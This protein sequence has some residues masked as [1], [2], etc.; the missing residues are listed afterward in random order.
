MGAFS[1]ILIR[2]RLPIIIGVVVVTALLGSSLRFLRQEHDVLKFLPAEDPDIQLFRRASEE[3]GG[4]DVAV[5]GVESPR[6]F[7]NQGLSALRAMT[8][9]VLAVDGVYH[10]LSLTE[11]PH[12]ESTEEQFTIEPLV[13]DDIPFDRAALEEIR[14][15]VLADEMVSGRLAST[16]GQAALILCF[17]EAGAPMVGVAEEIRV[18][19][20]QHSG[21]MTLYYGG[22][23]FIQEHIGDGTRRD[24]I[25]LTPYVMLVSALATFIFFRRFLGAL[26]VLS[27]VALGAVWTLGGMAALGAPMTVV[28]TSLPMVLVAIGGAYGAHVLAAFYVAEGQTAADRVTNAL[29]EVGPPV[30]ASMLTTVAGFASFLAMDVAPMRAFGIQASVGVFLCALAALVVI[31]AVLSYGGSKTGPAPAEALAG[32]IWWLGR[33]TNRRRWLTMGVVIGVSALAGSMAWRVAPNTSIKN[34]FRPDSEPARANDFLRDR[35]GGSM[36]VHVYMQGDM[37]D[38]VV[39]DELRSIAEEARSIEGVTRITTHLDTLERLS[40]GLSGLPRLPRTPRHVGALQNFMAGNPALRQLVDDNL[41]RA[42]VQITLSSR[43]SRVV[44]PVV[45]RLRTFIEGVPQAVIA[46]NIYGAG[47]QVEQA[48]QR[49]LTQVANRVLRLL[50]GLGRQPPDDGVEGIRHVLEQH[51]VGWNLAPGD[52][53]NREV[54]ASAVE[55]FDSD[56]SPFDPFDA[57]ALGQGLASLARSPVTD[58][59]LAEALPPLLPEE[60]ASDAEGVEIAVPV[61]ARRLSEA[62]ARVVAGRTL[63]GVLEA[64]GLRDADEETTGIVR[65]ALEELDDERVGLP[66]EPGT[67]G[68]EVR[69][70]E[71]G[72]TGMAVVNRAFRQSTQR[73]QIMSL[74]VAMLAL[75]VLGMAMFR[76]VKLGFV[77]I[78]PSGLTLLIT[79][80]LMGWLETP[81]DPGTC[82]VAALSLG[83]GIDYAIHFLWRRRWRKLSLEQTCRTVGPA[84]VFNAVEVASGF[85]VMIAATTVPLS[86]FGFLVM[87]AMMVAALATLTVLPALERK[88]A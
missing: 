57:S 28:S 51:F 80:G 44:D 67:S 9:G 76:S 65:R 21:H 88:G 34:F 14:R 6:L 23:P 38:P 32:P 52:D 7:T 81:L 20:R 62:R 64:G 71:T 83:I 3:F 85:A 75:L 8:R 86:R 87:M 59:R 47:E 15:K 54:T 24:I 66:C 72:V 39:L 55:F 45:D 82:M 10:S 74:A 25:G 60:L 46:V 70:I 58:R 4:L 33:S 27:S 61:L 41:T 49:R 12:L 78:L 19:M 77:A 1:S 22:L 42:I 48:R 18:V 79:F 26:L 84:I 29:I 5:V 43:D 31:P 63:A 30:Y 56:D 16:D 37:R 69:V 68:A 35:F 2:L 36:F 73:N 50:R 13:P 53:L 40:A 11:M 17:L